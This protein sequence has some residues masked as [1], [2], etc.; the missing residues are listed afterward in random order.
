MVITLGLD[1]GKRNGVAW[2]CG[3]YVLRPFENFTLFLVNAVVAVN[4]CPFERTIL[5]QTD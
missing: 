2:R 3:E 1:V 4:A 5:F